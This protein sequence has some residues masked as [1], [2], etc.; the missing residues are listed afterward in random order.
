M[1]YDEGGIIAMMSELLSRISEDERMREL[2]EARE[3][4]AVDQ[5]L[6]EARI[7]E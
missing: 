3:K 6:R 2:A 4:F 1:K 5:F 7:K